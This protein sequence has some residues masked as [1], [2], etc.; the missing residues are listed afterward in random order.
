MIV[1]LSIL[2]IFSQIK[3]I[4]PARTWDLEIVTKKIDEYYLL[5]KDMPITF[6][7]EGPTYIRVYTRIFW[8]NKSS[9]KELY[10][11]ILQENAIDERLI[12]LESERSEVTTDMRGR[13]VSKWRTFYI[14]V[15]EGMNRYKITQWSSPNDSMLLKFTYESPREWHDIPAAGYSA[16]LEAVEEEKLVKYY[17]VLRDKKVTLRL[18]G[19]V[20][21]KVIARLNYDMS[22]LGEQSYS[23][24]VN[25]NGRTEQENIKCYKSDIITYENRPDFVPSNAHTFYIRVNE[26]WHNLEFTLKGTTAKSAALRFQREK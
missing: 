9:K 16:L 4:T 8:S 19:P 1:F 12:T 24:L 7:V 15:P 21:L 2:C 20:S 5:T 25:D 18:Q 6:S 14:E 13:P 3:D 26:G 23:L 11:V 10:K 17:E 22:M